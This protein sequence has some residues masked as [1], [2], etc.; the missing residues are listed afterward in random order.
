MSSRALVRPEAVAVG[1]TRPRGL[2]KRARDAVIYVG[3]TA[4]VGFVLR[5][6]RRGQRAVGAVLAIGVWLAWRSGRRRVAANWRRVVGR[7][8]RSSDV[9]RCFLCIGALL[10]DTIRLLDPD[11][12]ANESLT[13]DERSESVFRDALGRGRGVVFV[14]AHLG[15]FERLAA[16]VADRG[17]PA[18]VVARESSDPRITQWYERVRRPRGVHSI[19]RGGHRAGVR[20]AKVIARGGAVGMLID[21]PARVPSIELSWLG[22]HSQVPVGPARLA[23]ATGCDVLVGTCVPTS[24]DEER[25]VSI[26]RVDVRGLGVGDAGER[27]LT[28]RIV[29][30]LEDRVRREPEAWLGM[31]RAA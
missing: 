24:K 8:A 14:S 1:P 17:L 6:S 30:V 20:A 7:E 26:V 25:R 27:E 3:L 28:E 23:L 4:F 13:L 12:L 22:G 15:P 16:V 31:F 9:R 5:L 18:V 21:L 11:V 19:Y 2:A 29:R 10:V